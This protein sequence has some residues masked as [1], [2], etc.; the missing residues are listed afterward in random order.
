MKKHTR[1]HIHTHINWGNNLP[2]LIKQ[3]SK[4][5]VSTYRQ[6]IQHGTY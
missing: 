6:S 4:Q 3:H 1:I 2:Q 5:K